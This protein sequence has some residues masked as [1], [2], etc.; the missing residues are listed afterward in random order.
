MGEEILSEPLKKRGRKS[1]TTDGN[2]KNDKVSSP[3]I[4]QKKRGR[5][6]NIVK[7][8]EKENGL[9]QRRG[10]KSKTEIDSKSATEDKKKVAKKTYRPK[11]RSCQSGPS[12]SRI[13]AKVELSS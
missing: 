1:M 11:S 4:P 5:K 7:E 13:Q 10:K 2:E 9:P 12:A 6:S 3:L 8:E